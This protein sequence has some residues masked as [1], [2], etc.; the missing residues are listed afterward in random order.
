MYKRQQGG[1]LAAEVLSLD[2]K[3]SCR[4]E[5]LISSVEE[6]RG[7][8]REL[9]ERAAELIGEARLAVEGK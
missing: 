2:G 7:V 6:A 8:G 5:G 4:V 9:R 1:R 3:K